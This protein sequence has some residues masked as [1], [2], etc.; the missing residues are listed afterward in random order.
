MFKVKERCLAGRIGVLKTKRGFLETPYLFPVIDL[1]RQEIPLSEIRALGFRGVITNAYLLFRRGFKGDITLLLKPFEVIMTDSGAYQYLEYGRIDIDNAT[2]IE[3]QKK[4][5]SDI[6]VILDVPTGDS[7]DRVWAE[8]TV[9]ETLRRAQEALK[10]VDREKRLWVLP[11]Q[12]GVHLELLEISAIESSNLEFDIYA[13]GSPTKMLER[14]RYEAILDMIFSV[15]R[16]LPFCKPLHLFGAGHPMMIPIAV[17]MGV[18][19]FDSASYILFA[20]QD[21]YMTE[22]GTKH[23][24][25]LEYLPCSCPV[26]HR[27][28]A[29]EL[30]EL[31]RAE[32]TRLLALHNLG[33]I[34]ATLK[35]TK[36]AIV[37][38]R[39]WELLEEQSRRHPRLYSAF[40][41]IAKRYSK[42]LEAFDPR[43]NRISKAVMLYDLLSLRNP[44]VGRALRHLR[45]EY[46]PPP[47]YKYLLLRPRTSIDNV[48]NEILT[49]LKDQV[50]IVFY[51]EVLGVIPSELSR[52]YPL[53]HSIT[54]GIRPWGPSKSLL[55]RIR[56]YVLKYKSSYAMPIMIEVCREWDESELL[57]ELPSDVSFKVLVVDC[58]Y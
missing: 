57:K 55:R 20:R 22:A 11:I 51:D 7:K 6:A 9:R 34:S 29:R 27:L 45:T 43:I 19:L 16:N 40:V 17:A 12:G 41:W 35:K 14:Y 39:L 24:S 53:G 2:I 56:E 26:C 30:R 3:Y 50:H 10:L 33:V 15:R 1:E 37:E 48:S 31:N 8:F 28:D 44:R 58:E 47:L 54:P 42:W 13:L 36:Q 52:T 5:N 32:R 21:R 25:E 38:G 18:D 4:I 23:V 49:R 46:S